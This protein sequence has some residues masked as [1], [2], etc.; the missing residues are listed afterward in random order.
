MFTSASLRSSRSTR[1]SP[2]CILAAIISG[3]QPA[4]SCPARKQESF[5]KKIYRFHSRQYLDIGVK[6]FPRHQQLDYGHVVIGH[7]P[8]YGQPVVV[9][10]LRGEP[11]V[12][13]ERRA[14]LA[15]GVRS[16]S[17]FG[18]GAYVR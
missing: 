3:V 14:G 10:A 6:V 9:V 11:R 1:S 7:G 18:S 16:C 13:L 17:H 5:Q 8:M 2:S 4:A 12:G 15:S